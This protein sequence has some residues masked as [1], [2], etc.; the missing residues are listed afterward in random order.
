[1]L[2]IGRFHSDFTG[3]TVYELQRRLPDQTI[4]TI[5]LETGRGEPLDAE[6]GQRRADVVVYTRTDQATASD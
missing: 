3:G 1:V 5:S 4:F 2:L 6:Q